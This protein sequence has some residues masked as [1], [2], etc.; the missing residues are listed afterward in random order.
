MTS[1]PVR[2]QVADHLITPQNA[3]F[4]LIDYQPSQLAGVHSMDR[5]LLVKNAVSTVRT[6]KAF[7]VPVVHSTINVATGRGKP[8]L[9]ELADLLTDDKPLDRT[10]TNSW[11]DIEFVQAVRATGRRKLI[12]CAL[13]TEICM[14]FTALD[15][16]REGYEVYPVV[17]AIGGTSPEAHRAG[18][19][20]VLQAGG[21]PVSWV[22]LAVELQRDWARQ[23]TVQAVI[24]IVLTD[25]LLK[26]EAI[27]RPGRKEVVDVMPDAASDNNSARDRSWLILGVIGLAQL[28]VVLDIT[29]MNIALPSAQRAL[30][31]TTA[32][33]Q[34]VVTAYTLAFG[35]LLLPGG[36]L[37]DLLGRKVTFLIGLAGFAGVSA[38]GGASV[39][40]TMLITAR[41][42]QGAFAALLVPSAL[43]LLTT[44]FTAPKDRGRA[45]AVYGAI[46]GPAARSA[47]CSAAR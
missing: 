11:E 47:C 23:D 18:L 2:D 15:A 41:A 24:E 7:G 3:A 39:N 33:R 40:F 19:D 13:W 22:S 1:A 37:A 34:W 46:A 28:M 8:T 14:A 5:D 45:F 10:T 25:R 44:T 31:F 21:Q 9:P 36:R 12:I 20:R 30:G 38:I 26:E 35:S 16:L 27:A 4:L 29:V 43:S 42:C 32:D 6:I 17:D